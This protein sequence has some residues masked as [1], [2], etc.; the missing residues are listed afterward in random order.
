MNKTVKKIEILVKAMNTKPE[1]GAH[2]QG[3]EQQRNAEEQQNSGI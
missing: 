1:G 2:D 3:N